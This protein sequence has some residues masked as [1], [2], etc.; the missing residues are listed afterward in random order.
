[1]P[2]RFRYHRGA[3]KPPNSRIVTRPSR[4]GNPF[5]LAPGERGDPAAHAR[6]VAQ[7]RAWITAPEQADLLAAARRELRGLDLGCTC[8]PGLPCHADVL[9]ELINDN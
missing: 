9:L 7:F 4:F 5:R 8:P 3:L 2:T 6:V 1:M